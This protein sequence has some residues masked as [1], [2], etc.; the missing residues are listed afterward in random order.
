MIGYENWLM[1]PNGPYCPR[2]PCVSGN[3]GNYR[4]AIMSAPEARQNPQRCHRGFQG[5]FP[6]RSSREFFQLN[7]ESKLDCRDLDSWTL[8]RGIPLPRRSTS[9]HH[10]RIQLFAGSPWHRDEAQ[11]APLDLIAAISRRHRISWCSACHRIP[12]SLAGMASA[13]KWESRDTQTF[14]RPGGSASIA[15]PAF[16]RV[17]A[18]YIGDG[19][20]NI[21]CID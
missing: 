1:K 13:A 18:R 19:R 9:F 21:D 5:K 6:T 12:S 20:Q 3:T 2:I 11:R 16:P 4:D 14:R 17:P 7:R 8:C 15:K 10:R